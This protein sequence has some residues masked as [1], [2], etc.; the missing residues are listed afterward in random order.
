MFEI[1]CTT[2]LLGPDLS[3]STQVTRGTIFWK[4][5]EMFKICSRSPRRASTRILQ[6]IPPLQYYKYIF[7]A[8]HQAGQTA[9]P[10][11]AQFAPV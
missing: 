4:I 10:H 2:P 1:S 7:I 3:S 11:W 5:S 9:T 6:K 8:S